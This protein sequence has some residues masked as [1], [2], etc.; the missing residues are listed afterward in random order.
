VSGRTAVITGGAS[1]LGAAAA[2]RLREDGARV[3]TVDLAST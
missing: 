2:E 3:I 1:G